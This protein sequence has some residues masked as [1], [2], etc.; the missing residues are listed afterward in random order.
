MSVEGPKTDRVDD[1]LSGDRESVIL[2][3]NVQGYRI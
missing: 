1:T 3:W 2:V